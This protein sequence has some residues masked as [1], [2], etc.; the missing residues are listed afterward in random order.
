MS[1]SCLVCFLFFSSVFSEE[2]EKFVQ[3][4]LVVL[5]L[6]ASAH[7]HKPVDT[8]VV[9]PPPHFHLRPYRHAARSIQLRDRTNVRRVLRRERE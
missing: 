4:L 9:C 7:N 1:L 5:R 2:G 6:V 3:V 8:L